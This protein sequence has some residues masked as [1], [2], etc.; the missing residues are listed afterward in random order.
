MPP[1]R[2]VAADFHAALIMDDLPPGLAWMVDTGYDRLNEPQR[3]E[4]LRCLQSGFR[5]GSISLAAFS[6]ALCS[7]P[8]LTALCRTADAKFPLT[9]TTA[10]DDLG[11]EE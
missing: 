6:D 7:G 8:A 4:Y 9:I 11:P 3:E 5:S 1:P 10:W 2:P